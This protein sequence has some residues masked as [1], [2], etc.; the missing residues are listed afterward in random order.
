MQF[1]PLWARPAAAVAVVASAAAFAAPAIAATPAQF[2]MKGEAMSYQEGQATRVPNTLYYNNGR[3][4]LEMAQPVSAEGTTA[5]SVVL[6]K[7]GGTTITMLNP[8]EKQAMKLEAASLEAVT[9]N[10]ALQKIASFR[11]SEFGRTFRANSKKVGSETVAGQPC[12]ILEHKGKDGHFRLWISDRYDIPLR[13][14]YYEGA[15]PAFSYACSQLALTAN[16][17]ASAFQVPGGYEVTDLS[18]VVNGMERQ[19]HKR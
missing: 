3:I 14:T 8:Q 2:T 4:R 12:S 16:L 11:L 5:F 6:A 7:E 10:N 15:K 13:F 19:H 1:H 17:P 9:E 18:E